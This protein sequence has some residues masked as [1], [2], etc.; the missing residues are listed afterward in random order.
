M[1]KLR[2]QFLR[3]VGLFN[4]RRRA[5]EF[6]DELESNLQMHI[7]ENLRA[8]MSPD[9]A[10]YAALRKFGNVAR[11]KEDAWELWSFVWIEQLWQDVRFGL[12]MIAKK[13]GFSVVVVLSLALGI[14]ANTAI[15]S[16][17]DAVLLKA[18]P[19]QRPDELV[20]LS[21]SGGRGT[22]DYLRYPVGL[23]TRSPAI[24][25]KGKYSSC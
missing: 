11:V 15:F 19:V 20:V 3:L 24:S 25:A 8:G 12:R 9:E 10:R 2:A 13:P 16:L 18:L 1:R 21:V 7:E 5:G 6:A 14:G 22:V 23:R 17:V 4:R